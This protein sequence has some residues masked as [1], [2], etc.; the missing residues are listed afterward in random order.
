MNNLIPQ[1]RADK[2]GKLV[3]R[4]VRADA[5]PATIRSSIPKPALTAPVPQVDD[6]DKPFALG[7]FNWR[8]NNKVIDALHKKYNRDE[9]QQVEMTS[10]EW[11]AARREGL[12]DQQIHYFLLAGITDPAEM[13]EFA[14]QYDR[15]LLPNIKPGLHAKREAWV[16]SLIEAG[17][18]KEQFDAAN[19]NFGSHGILT[20]L[21]DFDRRDS[22]A[23]TVRMFAEFP[24]A[25]T[26]QALNEFLYDGKMTLDQLKEIGV[27][28]VRK[29]VEIIKPYAGK[30]DAGDIG[31]IIKHEE[32]ASSLFGP[33]AQQRIR[34]R[35]SA[36]ELWGAD[37]AMEL[38]EPSPLM[39]AGY[40]MGSALREMD[41]NGFEF[42]KFHDDV[43]RASIL[44]GSNVGPNNRWHADFSEHKDYAHITETSFYNPPPEKTMDYFRTGLTAEE[45]LKGL[46]DGL[47][48][49]SARGIKEGATPAVASGWL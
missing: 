46:E 19:K 15:S 37:R 36:A 41:D 42:A 24:S 10:R 14:Q 16:D 18:T 30:V 47:S 43:I 35:L 32:K 27:T 44:T 1:L 40:E 13:R 11:L 21:N 5:K 2:T 29:Y 28:R 3:T 6:I 22:P 26:R 7:P 12:Y 8:G 20:A 31:R 23:D 48:A 9:S 4:H 33:K 39:Q 25:P 17:I 45:T 38:R 49:I 34:F